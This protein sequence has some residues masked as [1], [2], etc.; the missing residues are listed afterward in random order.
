MGTRLVIMGAMLAPLALAGCSGSVEIGQAIDAA[1]KS[2]SGVRPID[3]AL[4][5]TKQDA[6]AEASSES[7]AGDAG[8]S[9]VGTNAVTI[10]ASGLVYATNIVGETTS[11]YS[12][13]LD[14]TTTL[15]GAPTMLLMALSSATSM[16]FGVPSATNAAPTTSWGT[17]YRVRAQ[18]KT[19]NAE[20]A[21][22]WFRVDT[23]SQEVLGGERNP[24]IGT[25]DWQWVEAVLDVPTG[26]FEFAFGTSLTGTGEVWVGPITLDQ[27]SDCIPLSPSMAYSFDA[28]P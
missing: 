17:H 6:L 18:L 3:G 12:A 25:S 13:A 19:D 11:A 4:Q 20:S 7:S 10:P 2:D 23:S 15:D 24:I 22:L 1:A 26:T 8:C 9:T 14:D 28:G 27:V 16:T 21:E 5:D